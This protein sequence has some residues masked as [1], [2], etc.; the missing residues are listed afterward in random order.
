MTVLSRNIT[1][2]HLYVEFPEGVNVDNAILYDENN[3]IIEGGIIQ[4]EW[5][6]LSEV[7]MRIG[8][9]SVAHLYMESPEGVNVDNPI[10]YDEN[11]V[12]IERGRTIHLEL[13]KVNIPINQSSVAHA[14]SALQLKARPR[15]IFEPATQAILNAVSNLT[16]GDHTIRFQQKDPLLYLVEGEHRVQASSCSLLMSLTVTAE[17]VPLSFQIYSHADTKIPITQA[18]VGTLDEGNGHHVDI[19]LSIEADGRFAVASFPNS[20]KPE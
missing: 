11:N 2:A 5:L 8:Q 3:V 10:L 18:V 13:S 19:V 17:E 1:Y 14:A 15:Y 12:I 7:N 4:I 20:T 6:G 9:S 16:V